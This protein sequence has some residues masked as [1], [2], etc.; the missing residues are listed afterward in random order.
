MERRFLVRKREML[1]QCKVNAEKVKKLPHELS[2]FL[3]P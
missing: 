1:A 2:S 3:F